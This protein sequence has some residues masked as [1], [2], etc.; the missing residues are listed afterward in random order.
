MLQQEVRKMVLNNAIGNLVGHAGI[1]YWVKHKLSGID[2]WGTQGYIADFLFTG[3]LFCGIIAVIFVFM[4]RSK[5][6]KG[7]FEPQEISA[8][9]AGRGLPE[10]AWQAAA[11]IGLIGLVSV[12]VPLGIFLGLVGPVPL[13]P[14]AV[15]LSK[16]IWAAIAA[17]I[18][19]PVAIY[20]GVRTATP[21]TA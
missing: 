4:Y 6:A 8:I 18:I 20:H 14:L 12:L 3:F 16:G 7:E 1:T 5:T 11:V 17:A 19:T 21:K 2:A 10:N 9:P 13:S 15:S